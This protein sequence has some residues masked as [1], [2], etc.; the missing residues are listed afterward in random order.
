MR[1]GEAGSGGG[2][3]A[4][5]MQTLRAVVG[6]GARPPRG[7]QASGVGLAAAETGSDGTPDGRH[8]RLWV[9]SAGCGS[10]GD[11]RKRAIGGGRTGVGDQPVGSAH[12]AI[13]ATLLPVC[14]LLW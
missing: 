11:P 9:R 4:E 3:P 2:V 5:G 13:G 8:R 1:G 10:A 14:G 7:E 6:R 12:N